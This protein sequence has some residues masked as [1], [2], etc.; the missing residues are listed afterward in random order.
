MR[1]HSV[2]TSGSAALPSREARQARAGE[3][4]R[5]GSDRLASVQVL[6]GL[7]AMMVLGTHSVGLVLANEATLG[8]S[9]FKALGR[10]HDVGNAGVDLFFVISGFV[11]ALSAR[12]FTG[13]HGAAEF[14][15]QRFMRIAPLFYVICLPLALNLH[16]RFGGIP[17]GQLADT[18][19][20]IPWLDVGTY[21]GSVH[22]YG[23]TLAFEFVF[24]AIVAVPIALGLSR[25]PAVLL[26]IM[27]ALPALGLALDSA[28]IPARM[29]LN[30]ILLE[31]ALGVAAFVLW[32][33]G[34]LARLG[35]WTWWLL[36]LAVLAFVASTLADHIVALEPA[37]TWDRTIGFA[38]VLAWGLPAFLLMCFA[39]SPESSRLKFG[40]PLP[41][42][43]GDASYSIYLSQVMLL[44][45]LQRLARSGHA[46]PADLM[47]LAT[48][49]G[50]ALLGVIVYRLVERP[51]TTIA[52]SLVRRGFRRAG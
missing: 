27:L 47:I 6:R 50:G 3:R 4:A 23:W 28:W 15:V 7:A 49:V 26:G 13:A 52:Q 34:V 29:L 40:G 39:V 43:L 8:P 22:P 10:L 46:L 36:A 38:R 9:V 41:R 17:A 2:G 1:S 12:R 35:R 45:P 11:M 5:V 31:F 48:L 21:R 44:F 19:L 24:Y 25:R 32:E 42:I 18:I 51:L 33:R 30:E 37:R 14:L 20:F 16:F